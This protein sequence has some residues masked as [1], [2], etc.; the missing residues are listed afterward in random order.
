MKK[1]FISL[2]ILLS[3]P[4]MAQKDKD[5]E[6]KIAKNLDVFSSIYK[7]LDMLYVDT[8][9]ADTVIGNGIQAM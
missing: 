7:G 4:V 5:H 6:F 1:I 2:M 3:L 9:D 8:L